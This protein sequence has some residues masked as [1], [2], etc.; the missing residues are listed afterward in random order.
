M[1]VPLLPLLIFVLT[2]ALIDW[3]IY[4]VARKQWSKKASRIHLICSAA[5]WCLLAVALAMPRRGGSDATLLSIM[6]MLF[7]FA[8]VYLSK[9]LFVIV[10]FIGCIP[11]LLRRKRPKY[12]AT[13]ALIASVV[14]F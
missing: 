8:T 7:A 5:M 1:R 11:C 2:F 12:A 14:L 10:D 13:V 6:W 3:R 4:A 9:T